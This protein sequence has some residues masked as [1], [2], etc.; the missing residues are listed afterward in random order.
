LK[1]LD[2]PVKGHL[3][4]SGAAK[5]GLQVPSKGGRYGTGEGGGGPLGSD[6]VGGIG[7]LGAGTNNTWTGLTSFGDDQARAKV[8]ASDVR[9]VFG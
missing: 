1:G 9:L 7:P 6:M 4:R 2:V 5:L 8:R 3:D